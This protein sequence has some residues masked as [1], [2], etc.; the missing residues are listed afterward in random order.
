MSYSTR[1]VT[2]A[3]TAIVGCYSLHLLWSDATTNKTKLSFSK[4]HGCCC[5]EPLSTPWK[6]KNVLI[7][8][9]GITGSLTARQLHQHFNNI[10][11]QI[12][13]IDIFERASYPAG[14]FGARAIY[15]DGSTAAI[16]DVGAQVLST[17]NADDFR[18]LGGHGVTKEN[19]RTAQS[20]VNSL[21]QENLLKLVPDTALGET[22]ERMIWEGLWLHY[23]APKGLTSVIQALLPQNLNV[24]FEVRVDSIKRLDDGRFQVCGVDRSVLTHD[25]QSSFSKVYDAVIICI[26]APDA[27]SISGLEALLDEP[28]LHVLKNVGYDS[29]ICEAHF[30]D[31]R[32][33]SALT[34]A[35]SNGRLEISVDDEDSLKPNH[36]VSYLSWQDPKRELAMDEMDTPCAIAVH[37]K[38]G[39]IN[40]FEET[41]VDHILSQKTGLPVETIHRYRLDKKSIAW[42]VSQMIRPM[43]AVVADPPSDSSWQCLSTL[44]GSLVICGDFMTQSSFL[45]CVASADAA[46][47]TVL[48]FLGN[49]KKQ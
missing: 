22:D 34:K 27:L 30:F 3:G 16:A 29:R 41:T 14:R 10:N 17:V 48:K 12:L 45:G 15:K 33:R 9:C 36:N 32:L 44:S 25:Q 47:K 40:T 43:E 6:T 18:A 39:R 8:G 11:N 24:K 5:C 42:Y 38:A 23:A 19:L 37:S 28:A 46:A 21:V 4:H 1:A 35:F 31:P 26:P 20:M 7:V 49:S 13:K 2:L